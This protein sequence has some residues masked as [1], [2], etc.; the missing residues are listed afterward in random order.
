MVVNIADI[1]NP[2]VISA[3]NIE[4]VR[5]LGFYKDRLLAGGASAGLQAFALP[6]AYVQGTSVAQ[7]GGFLSS[8]TSQEM[9]LQFNEIVDGSVGSR[10]RRGCHCS[11]ST[12]RQEF[13]TPVPLTITPQFENDQTNTAERFLLEFD[14]TPGTVLELVVNDA[15]N[16][17]GTGLWARFVQRFTI[18]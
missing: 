16:A 10:Q 18:A 7:E 11:A 15:Y 17:R 6:H 5:G 9:L 14:R 13:K 1:E 2:N 4:S 8:D 12:L 3:G